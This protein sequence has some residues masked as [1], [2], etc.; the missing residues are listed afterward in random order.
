MCFN[1]ISRREKAHGKVI[2]FTVAHMEVLKSLIIKM[3]NVPLMKHL[4]FPLN[5]LL[6]LYKSFVLFIAA[7]YVF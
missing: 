7:H 1:V 2:G 5:V 4:T 6:M 3:P